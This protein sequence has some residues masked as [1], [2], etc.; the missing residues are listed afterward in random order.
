MDLSLYLV[1]FCS[2]SILLSN[3]FF[4]CMVLKI[5]G[6]NS[7]MV[8]NYIWTFLTL[9]RRSNT[10][11]F[12]MEKNSQMLP[13]CFFLNF[14]IS[15]LSPEPKFSHLYLFLLSRQGL[16]LVGKAASK[17][18]FTQRVRTWKNTWLVRAQ[19]SFLWQCYTG[20]Y[21]QTQRHID[22]RAGE[23]PLESAEMICGLV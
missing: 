4:Q 21:C 2:L 14:S 8:M 6:S 7:Y 5:Q 23:E 18:R 12:F 19:A 17:Q 10:F 22:Q 13:P 1:E 16:Q 15:P 9:I 20:D 11:F 3:H